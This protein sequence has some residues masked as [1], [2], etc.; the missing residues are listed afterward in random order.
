M[1][2][3]NVKVSAERKLELLQRIHLIAGMTK[4]YC[5]DKKMLASLNRALKQETKKLANTKYPFS[6]ADVSSLDR[7]LGDLTGIVCSFK[8]AKKAEQYSLTATALEEFFNG[9]NKDIAETKECL[10]EKPEILKKLE[11]VLEKGDELSAKIEKKIG[12][13][14][15]KLKKS[16]RD[17][18]S[19]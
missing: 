13:G 15:E 5:T 1:D 19:E 18:D 17:R 11:T 3:N 12:E 10:T 8:K 14:V 6:D 4:E 2:E 9:I 7:H 16:L